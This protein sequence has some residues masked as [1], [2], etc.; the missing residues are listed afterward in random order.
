MK[1]NILLLVTVFLTGC[2]KEPPVNADGV[3]C[4]WLSLPKEWFCPM[5]KAEKIAYDNSAL[6]TN[7]LEDLNKN[8]QNVKTDPDLKKALDNA[9]DD[10]KITNAEYVILDKIIKQALNRKVINDLKN[11]K[12]NDDHIQEQFEKIEE[13]FT[14]DGKK[15][16]SNH[17]SKLK[18]E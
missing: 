16:L 6:T 5:T 13:Y 1:I 18:G 9:L 8:I 7:E 10:N 17:I 4:E 3:K 12:V 11:T 15:N 2:E 14:E